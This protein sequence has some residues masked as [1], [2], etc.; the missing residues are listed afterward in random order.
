MTVY[1]TARLL[2]VRA[3]RLSRSVCHC[4]AVA[5]GKDDMSEVKLIGIDETTLRRGHQ[6]LTVIYDLDA[7]R[8][9]FVAEGCDH[10]R[11]VA[12]K[13][14]LIAHDGVVA[15]VEHVGMDIGQVYIKG[16]TEQFSKIMARALSMG[17]F[18]FRAGD[19]S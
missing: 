8:L 9:L 1:K 7:N 6:Y 11:V 3:H 5:C 13:A 19:R 2:R 17:S 16:V 12:F 14:D 4:V 10:E 15:A 18:K